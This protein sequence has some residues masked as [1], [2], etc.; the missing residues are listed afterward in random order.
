MAEVKFFKKTSS[1]VDKNDGKDKTAVNFYIKCGDVLVPVQVRY[2][3]DKTTGEDSHY[4]ERKVL[5]TAF[6]EELPNK[7]DS[8]K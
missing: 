7:D 5:L 1:Y 3:E 6:A 4:R 2:F 8:G